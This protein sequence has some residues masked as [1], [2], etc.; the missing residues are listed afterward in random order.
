MRPLPPSSSLPPAHHRPV[1]SSAEVASKTRQG[2]SFPVAW[3]VAPAHR[4]ALLAYYAFARRGDDLADAPHLAI[5]DKIAA[6]SALRDG[7]TADDAQND[8]PIESQTV[9]QR[10]AE[11]GLDVGMLYPL[12][13]AFCFDAAGPVRLQSAADLEQYCTLSAVPVGR[14]LLALHGEHQ[15]QTQLAACD[16]LCIALQS[17]NHLQGLGKDWRQNDRCYLPQQW[18]SQ[19]DCPLSHL[20]GNQCSPQLRRAITLMQEWTATLLLQARPLPDLLRSRRLA[21]QAAATLS[22]AHSL[23]RCLAQTDP[24]R[25]SPS[26]R[27]REWLRAGA[28][29]LPPLLRW[30]TALRWRRSHP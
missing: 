20:G 24:L 1:P 11:A 14:F 4:P 28:A 15:D 2:E 27:P 23:Q 17:L 8:S 19:A 18:L 21:A 16:A 10:F 3:I 29:S 5:A 6:L 30:P 12:L 26:L 7:L 9:R 22:T 13:D 25:S